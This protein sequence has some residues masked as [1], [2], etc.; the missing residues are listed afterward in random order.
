MMEMWID[1]R[2]VNLK[3]DSIHFTR[4]VLALRE[5]ITANSALF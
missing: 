5:W 4:I 2:K 1:D 3:G